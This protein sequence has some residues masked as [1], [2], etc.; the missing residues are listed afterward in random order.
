MEFLYQIE[1]KGIKI[2]QC[3]GPL[4]RVEIPAQI[5]EKEVY[6][7]ADYAFS[8]ARR[9]K[10]RTDAIS[11]SKLKEVCLPDTLREIGGYAF[12]GCWNLERMEL[13][14]SMSDI[15]GG[16]FTGCHRL[17]ELYIHMKDAWGYCFKDI[18]SELR[19]ELKVTL[20]YGD[21]EEARLLFPEYYEE[22]VENTPAR[23]L[24][25]HFHGSGYRYR[26]CFQDGRF[27]YQEY[28]SL[29]YE[30][31]AWESDDFCIELALLRLL[32]PYGLSED[33]KGC[34]Q[35]FLME[36]RMTAALW[37]LEFEQNEKLEYISGF[38]EWSGEELEDLI[39]QANQM[40]RLEIQSFLMDYKSKHIRKKTITFEW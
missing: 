12:Y 7:L 6:A 29:F 14:H 9:T 34:Y 31:C 30:A 19:H 33:A 20:E 37:C 18:I 26:Q 10:Q 24:E 25:T 27:Q 5:E 40:G 15:A 13:Y 36:N 39:R 38:I 21:G 3:C 23:I 8:D 11:G 1:E 17:K 32:Y 4:Q 35:S 2:E 22:A 28:D 16:A